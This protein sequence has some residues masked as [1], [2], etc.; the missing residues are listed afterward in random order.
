MKLTKLS[1]FLWITFLTLLSSQLR[2]QASYESLKT[3]LVFQFAHNVKWENEKNFKTFT[4]GIY[5]NDSISV[6]NFKQ[7]S[8]SKKIKKL[9]VKIIFYP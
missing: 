2:A 6:A 1:I 4:I 5:G 7:L 3:A 9:N 8:K